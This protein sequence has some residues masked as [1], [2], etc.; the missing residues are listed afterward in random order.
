MQKKS[1]IREKFVWVR[2]R[3]EGFKKEANIINHDR[4]KERNIGRMG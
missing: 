2:A 4:E 3:R 1:S